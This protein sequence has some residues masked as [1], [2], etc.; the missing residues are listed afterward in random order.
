MFSEKC[1]QYNFTY[2]VGN[3][4]SVSKSVLSK[5]N[6]TLIYQNFVSLLPDCTGF[7]IA[8]IADGTKKTYYYYGSD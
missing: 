2:V 6:N 8:R 1:F 3:F 4:K 7:K 5:K